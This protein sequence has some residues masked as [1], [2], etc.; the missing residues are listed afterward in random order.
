MS[1]G[2]VR[3]HGFGVSTASVGVQR[4]VYDSDNRLIPLQDDTILSSTKEYSSS[5]K[6]YS[7]TEPPSTPSNQSTSS[8]KEHTSFDKEFSS[9]E[10]SSEEPSIDI[11]DIAIPNNSQF[12]SPIILELNFSQ[13][14]VGR[15]G[16]C[17]ISHNGVIITSLIRSMS[18]LIIDIITDE[19]MSVENVEINTQLSLRGNMFGDEIFNL[20]LKFFVNLSNNSNSPNYM[21]NGYLMK[22]KHHP[23]DSYRISIKV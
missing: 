5:S 9:T 7:S 22:S 21:E 20:P 16:S 4:M 12:L 2:L 15:D 18:Y 3:L 23:P 8:D 17:S 14:I 10:P 19:N 1:S 13:F 6:V 11:N